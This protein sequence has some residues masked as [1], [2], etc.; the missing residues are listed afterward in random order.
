MFES[1][2]E[3]ARVWS[4]KN[5]DRVKL[6]HTYLVVAASLLIGAGIIGLINH[7]LGQNIL[8]IAII[9]AAMF[10]V[11]AVVWSL[12]QSALLVR[13]ASKR[14]VSTPRKK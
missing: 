5:D 10:L 9:S 7:D 2:K 1:I 8:M 14:T 12:V 13:L 3:S 4:T 11:N 6:Q